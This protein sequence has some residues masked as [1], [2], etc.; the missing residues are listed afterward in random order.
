M[1]VL[2]QP[3]ISIPQGLIREENLVVVCAQW[4]NDSHQQPRL[5]L[6]E[7]LQLEHL[8]RREHVLTSQAQYEPR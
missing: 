3:I 7:R 8:T 6:D 2:I 1:R 5:T 4:H